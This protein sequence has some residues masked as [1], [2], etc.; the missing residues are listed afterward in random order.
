MNRKFI[1]LCGLIFSQMWSCRKERNLTNGE[2]IYRNGI[3]QFGTEVLD[4]GQ[5]KITIFKSCQGCHGKDG[6]RMRSC[7]IRWSYLSNAENFKVPYNDTL[8][9]RFIDED[10][11]SDGTPAQTGVHWNLSEKDK[12]DL[13]EFLKGL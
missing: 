9:Y 11:K 8:F 13:L 2:S 7:T 5:S 10:L 6:D 1:L 3:D 12:K 4:K